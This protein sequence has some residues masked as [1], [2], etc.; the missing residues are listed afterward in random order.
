MLDAR[1]GGADSPISGL[2]PRAPVAS[3]WTLL[4]R[5]S[6]ARRIVVLNLLALL[7]VTAG[8]LYISPSRE[9]LAYQRGLSL[10]SEARLVASVFEIR[11]DDRAAT[12]LA[13]FLE[14]TAQS[15]IDRLDIRGNTLVTVYGPDVEPLARATFRGRGVPIGEDNEVASDAFLLDAALSVISFIHALWS[16]EEAAP[17]GF[18]NVERQIRRSA[19]RALFEGT[20]LA[21]VDDEGNS[22]L[23][24]A[25]PINYE[26]VTIGVVTMA[27]LAGEID[28]LVRQEQ[29]QYLRLF[30]IGVAVS[31]WLSLVLASTIADPLAQLASAAEANQEATLR[32]QALGQTSIP[33]LSHRADEIGRLSQALRGMV[34]ALYKRIEG[35]EQFAADVAHEIKNPLASLQSA[36]GTFR[37]AKRED[38][39]ERLLGVIEHDVKRLDRLVSDIS[40]ASRLD[41]ELVKE[42]EARF[43][44]VKLLRTLAENFAQIAERSGVEMVVDLPVEPIW[45]T[46]LEDRLAQVFVNLISN[47]LSFCT[48]GDAI[49]VWARARDGRVLIGVEDTG[50]GI[51][52]DS[53]TKIFS[54]FYS[55]R[56]EGQFGNNSGLGLAI[57][58]QIVD[59][60][61]GVIFA[62][63]IRADD[64][65]VSSPPLGARLIVG[66]P[67]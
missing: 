52:E 60:H 18:D 24:V 44:M 43:D 17:P 4:R 15:S 36:V 35:N 58:K 31:I 10:V 65:D 64:A 11:L 16:D 34:A 66:I 51:P 1:W 23:I 13:T 41:S 53:L 47:A 37:Y 6:L 14:V 55:E 7:L 39:R 29:E 27:T 19:Q 2:G 63:N 8:V 38:Q 50:P 28:V 59:A 61:G 3:G 54:R 48:D 67:I 45:T 26:D 32:K 40:N 12:D 42:Q 57:S 46:G 30:L 25:T 62:E 5:S 49:R 33:D 21:A 56:P 9:S 20:R 22:T